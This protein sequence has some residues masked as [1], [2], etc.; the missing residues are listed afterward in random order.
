MIDSSRWCGAMLCGRI[1][2]AV[3]R[4]REGQTPEADD[5]ILLGTGSV[6]IEAMIDHLRKL[7]SDIE[8]VAVT[9]HASLQ[10]PE[11]DE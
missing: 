3:H 11:K 5:A 10:G 1:A 7:F 2:A 4:R 8:A 6:V 9:D